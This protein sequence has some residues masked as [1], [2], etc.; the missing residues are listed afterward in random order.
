MM[1][2]GAV[3]RRVRP[4]WLV[5]RRGATAGGSPRW[6]VTAVGQVCEG[7]CKVTIELYQYWAA[8]PGWPGG[9]CL[10]ESWS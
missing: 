10:P 4:H 6:F 8:A 9:T 7:T 2:T 1:V 5:F 3:Y